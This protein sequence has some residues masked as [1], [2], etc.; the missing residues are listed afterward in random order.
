MPVVVIA[1]ITPKPG[2]AD[3][4]REVLTR[5]VPAVHEEPGCEFYALHEADGTFIFVE[6][7]TDADALRVHNTAPALMQVVTELA[8][9]LAGPPDIKKAEPI[10]AGDPAKGALVR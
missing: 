3:T 8:E 9:H 2:S 7:W 1:T 4:V 10:P 5:A 6:Q